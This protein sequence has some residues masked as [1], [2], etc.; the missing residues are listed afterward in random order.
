MSMLRVIASDRT[1][2]RTTPAKMTKAPPASI[3]PD[4]RIS[5]SKLGLLP[6]KTPSL[7]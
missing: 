4:A 7:A 3:P 2:G 6:S 5:D 1:V